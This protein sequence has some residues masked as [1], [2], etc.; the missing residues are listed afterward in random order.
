MPIDKPIA[1][2]TKSV[3]FDGREYF[4]IPKETL[5]SKRLKVQLSA[6]CYVK[7]GG[8]ASFRLVR[9]DGSPLPESEFLVTGSEPF[10]VTRVLPFGEGPGCVTPHWQAYTMQAK[11]L[12]KYS[13]PVCRR[14]SLCF[15][16]I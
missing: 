3:M 8:A 16:H 12:E 9:G 6:S 5:R 11:R 14:F 2:L 10:L 13:L 7:N 15:I 1:T 4:S